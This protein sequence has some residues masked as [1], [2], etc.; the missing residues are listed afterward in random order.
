M[1][2][3]GRLLVGSGERLD[4]ADLLSL[5]SYTA[6][7]FKYL[8]QSFIGADKPYI[9]HGLDVISPQDAIGT[10]NISIRIADSIVYYPGSKA[11]SFY[12][13]LEE[14]NINAQPLLP[15][16]RKNATN[17]VYITFSTFDTAKDSR[18][19]WDPDQNGGDGGE[20][21]QDVNTETALKVEVNVSVS[22]FP[23]NTIPIC[24][25]VV[26]ASVISS[27]QDC[28]DHFFRLGTGG[29][30]P[31]P[32]ATYS[33]RNEPSISYARLEPPTTMTSALNPNPFQGGDKNIRTLK[34]WMDVVMTRLK[35]LSGDTYWYQGGSFASPS[36]NNTFLD[37]LGSTVKS[38]GEW[39]HSSSIPG[40]ATWTEDIHYYSLIDSRDLIIRANSVTLSSSDQV[41]WIDLVRGAP[42]NGVNAAVDWQNGINYVNG[43]TGSF[44]N[45]SK[46]DWVKKNSDANSLFLRVEEF[47]AS[48]A[49][50]G[51]TTTPALAQSIRLSANYTGTTGTE[52]GHYTK[53]E[54]EL[55]DI[56]ITSRIDPSI[57]AVGGNFFWLAYRSD[58]SLG[59]VSAVRTT[60]TLNITE[61]DG[62]RA[63][64]YSVGHGLLDG[65]RITIASGPYAGTHVVEFED[66]DNV[67]IQ[68]AVTG[69]DLGRAAYYAIITTGSRN[70]GY[71]FQ[72]ESANHGFKSNERVTLSGASA[73]FDGSYDINVRSAT[74]FQIA[75]SGAHS[76]LGAIAGEIVNL[77]R[78]NVR[79][80]F[81]TVK[82]V[83]GESTSIGDLD[84]QNILSY[85][86]MTSLAQ[87]TPEYSIPG[88]YNALD[89]FQNFNSSPTDNITVRVSKI[90]AMMADRVQDRSI[91]L[92]GRTNIKSITSG[93]NQNI[94]AF[95]NLTLK[96]PSSPDQ[97]VNLTSPIPLPANSVIVMDIDR[98]SGTAI[99]PYVQSLGSQFLLAENKFI[100]FYRFSDTTVYTWKGEAI[101]PFGHVNTDYPE[102]SQNRNIWVYNPGQIRL[103]L[104]S[105]L[106]TL[107]VKEAAEVTRITTVAGSSVPTSSYFTFNAALDSTEY[108]AWYKVNGIGTDP[109]LVGK[110]GILVSILSTDSAAVVATKTITALNATAG[111]DITATALSN[112]ITLT[113]DVVG[114][115]TDTV[116]GTPSTTFTIETITQGF[117]P[118]I[119]ITISGASDNNEIDVNAINLLGT[120]TI[121]DG[122]SVWLRVN[123]LAYKIFN[124][125][126]FADTSDTDANGTLFI[127]NTTDVPI[128]QD[129]F[130]LWSRVGNNLM[131]THHGHR[132]DGNVYDETLSV[133]SG[134]AANSYEVTGPISAGTE[135]KLPLDSRDSSSVQEYVVGSGQLEVFL[136][137]QYLVLGED[138]SEIGA[139]DSL[140]RRIQI[141]Q[142]LIVGDDITFRIDAH[143]A[144]YFAASTGGGG[145]LQDSYDAGRFINVSVGQP[146]VITGASGKLLSVQGDMEVTGVIDPSG[147]TFSQSIADPLGAT[148]YGIWRNASDHFIFKRGAGTA[149]NLNTDFLRRD[150]TL[151]MLADLD[152]GSFK[153]TN[154]LSP[155]L[156]NDAANKSYVDL[157]LK[158][159]GTNA[160]TANMNLGNFR[161]NNVLDPISAQDAATK[162]YVDSPANKDALY[163]YLMN[164]TGSTINAGSIVMLSTTVT[165]DI[166]LANANALATSESVAGVVLNNISN[167]TSGYIQIAGEATVN[168]VAPL[169]LGKRVYVSTTAGSATS[170]PPAG[171]GKVVFVLGFATSANSVVLHP[172]LDT[173][174]ENVYEEN[175]AVVSGPPANDNE[176]TGPVSIGTTITLPFD[177]RNSN[178]VQSYT[179]GEGF[180][181]VYLNGQLLQTGDDYTESSS[182]TIQIQRAL[183]VDDDLTFRLNLSGSAYF[184]LGGG[185]GGSLQDAYDSGSTINVSVGVPV[186]INGTSGKLLVVNGDVEITGV[187]DPKALQLTPQVSNPLSPTQAGIWVDS[188]TNS[189]IYEDGISTSFNLSEA[190]A[191]NSLSRANKA[192]LKNN[193]GITLTRLTPVSVENTGKAN[194]V[195]VSLESNA[196]AVVGL[197][198][199]DTNHNTFGTVMTSGLMQD[200]II[201]ANYGDALYVSKTGG[202]TNIKPS[203]GVGGF[204]AGDF[205]IK[206]GVVCLSIVNPVGKDIIVMP[207]VIGQL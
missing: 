58:T 206:I 157:F 20:F 33:F 40:Q 2:V 17:F 78:M 162:A 190:A 207:H 149:I 167:A 77:V 66:S 85:L 187:I 183:S 88:S 59:L 62:E 191:G 122:Q 30:S 199:E 47:Y 97:T 51:G 39:Q 15:E 81:G 192:V 91:K 14:G 164:N 166:V 107:D 147:I 124:T 64:L 139:A 120:L 27:I 106:L 117:D 129:V 171:T 186:T 173:I 169:S 38:K 18:A 43:V 137:G 114:A 3:L 8:I 80:E 61:A 44:I 55:A 112:V 68:T 34:E 153:I 189:L 123:R 108:Y 12:Y 24:K 95:S 138:W 56:N 7:D 134:P 142:D 196:V 36:I 176:I 9:L 83:Q 119:Q 96:K 201:S 159:D 19:F 148:D 158:R 180:L 111:A 128:D 50:G 175:I 100:L 203:I 141:D 76:N 177:S 160:M 57:T 4:L 32:F 67:F 103:N 98:N 72:L 31:D 54:Y 126:A 135:L 35:E 53:G 13:G 65:D 145:S 193:S 99:T 63:R 172:H 163:L 28:R 37:A 23:E 73:Q 42:L 144:V 101:K 116:N 93:A 87:M 84:S 168:V 204:L 29:V 131:E 146:V 5:D 82:V 179:V 154:L 118:N 185:G 194:T 86:G 152:A 79:T 140:S 71:S 170:V 130:V 198:D 52:V 94:S 200:V 161:I 75:V 102:D 184:N 133:V 197:F 165:G 90:T 45:L 151:P 16:L 60:L 11:G 174:N 104:S 115:A 74:E 132:P 1:S 6:A 195:N 150:G 155:T 113:N 46:G 70:T 109:S 105:N 136:N 178:A 182:T 110:T 25:V 26:G 89:G 205:V 121:L 181:E 92:L 188:A 202:L 48:T 127:T 49:L 22:T 125:V 143:G 41:A 21:S 69:D 156:A 10:E